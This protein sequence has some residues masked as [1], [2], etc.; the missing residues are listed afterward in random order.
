MLLIYEKVFNKLNNEDIN[1]IHWKSN[2]HLE[3]A[4]NGDTDLDI[5]VTPKQ[6]VEFVHIIENEGFKLFQAVGKQSYI[7]IFDYV[8]LDVESQKVLHIHLHNRLMLGTKFFKE[9]LLPLDDKLFKDS[10]FHEKFPVKIINPVKE[11]ELL[12]VRYFLKTTYLSFIKNRFKISKDYHRE[13]EWLENRINIDDVRSNPISPTNKDSKYVENI[14]EFIREKNNIKNRFVLIRKT[15]KIFKAYKT[16]RLTEIKYLFIRMSMVWNYGSQ[17]LLKRPVPY[18]RIN[19][20]GG[21]IIAF[22]GA[23]GAGKSTVTSLLNKS[24]SKKIDVYFEYFGSG[25][26]KSSLL[27]KPLQLFLKFLKKSRKE[28]KRN[29]NKKNNDKYYDENPSILK[30][31]WALVLAVE[32]RNKIRCIW[33]AKAKGMI[34]I[35]DRYPQIQY[36]GIN[37]GPLLYGWIN[38]NGLKKKIALWEMNIYKMTNTFIPDLLIKMIVDNETAKTRKPKDNPID[39]EKKVKLI[40]GLNIPAVST[41]V[42]DSTK[43]LEEVISD[44]YKIVSREI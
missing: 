20:S 39:I 33:E 13:S 5:L 36:K 42:I 37:D 15:K 16:N 24:L 23:D 4:L 7:S 1:Y 18:R 44:V 40:N 38:K 3:A 6:Q 32:K 21:K 17:K 28:V 35:C 19:P 8:K 14:I 43:T 10:L 34:V 30:V 22:I 9:Y 25:D 26:G 31:I 29:D 11:L 12:W 27:R 41:Q 2:E